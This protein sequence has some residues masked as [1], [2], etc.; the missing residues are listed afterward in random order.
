[1][2]RT[3]SFAGFLM[4]FLGC[5]WPCGLLAQSTQWSGQVKDA[6]R[7]E[8][9]QGVLVQMEGF[10]DSVLTDELGRFSLVIPLQ[11]DSVACLLKH[12][13]FTSQRILLDPTA[14]AS[15]LGVIYMQPAD[16]E[17]YPE[18]IITLTEADIFDEEVLSGS[19]DFLQAS[20]DIFLSRVAFDFSPAF[21]R[22]RG[23]D[24][25]Y[26]EVYLNDI[27]MNRFY[28]GRPQWNNW[29]LPS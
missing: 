24:N 22:V 8:P 23:L 19:S 5:S 28:D 13:G 9:I 12:T 4:I 29:G 25:R 7:E 18:N 14:A 3:V 20:R 2:V 27:P 26:G 16:M 21:F 6:Q 17:T 15:D 1:M 10:L 11:L